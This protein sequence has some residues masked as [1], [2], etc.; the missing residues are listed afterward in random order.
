MSSRLQRS[1]NRAFIKQH[2]RCFY[3]DLPMWAAP[4]KD[5]MRLKC[6]A[7]HL[8]ARCD[9]G[10]DGSGNVVAAC[11]HCNRTRHLKRHPPPAHE[12]RVEVQRRMARGRWHCASTRAL[13]LRRLESE[14]GLE[15]GHRG[16]EPNMLI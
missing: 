2:G 9:G 14:Q 8:V 7:E 11:L 4:P 15:L 6:T 5:L 3:C 10:R 13:A 12:Y 16:S 1:R